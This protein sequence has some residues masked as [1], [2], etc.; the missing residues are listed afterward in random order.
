MAKSRNDLI[1]FC[2]QPEATSDVI[3]GKFVRLI[4]HDK[5]VKFSDPRLNCS[6]EIPPDDIGVGIVMATHRRLSSATRSNG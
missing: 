4:V 5:C 3:S 6:Q 2:T 1:A